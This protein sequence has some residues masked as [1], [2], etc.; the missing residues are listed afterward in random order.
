[1]FY[2]KTSYFVNHISIIE[3]TKSRKKNKESIIIA[4][5]GWEMKQFSDIDDC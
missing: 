5:M 3:K 2:I 4:K 1:M